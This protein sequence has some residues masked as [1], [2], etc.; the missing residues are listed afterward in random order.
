[1]PSIDNTS[2]GLLPD[3][4]KT[5]AAADP[6]RT[7]ELLLLNRHHMETLGRLSAGI[8]HEINTPL[9]YIKGNLEL[10]RAGMGRTLPPERIAEFERFISPIADGVER[11]A[12]TVNSM[13]GLVGVMRSYREERSV[14]VYSTLV[15]AARL[16]N[17]ELKHASPLYI[18]GRPFSITMDAEAETCKAT[19]NATNI[20]QVWLVILNNAIEAFGQSPLPFEERRIEVSCSAREGGVR[21]L[22]RDNAGPIPDEALGRMFELFESTKQGARASG[23]TWQGQ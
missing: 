9:T 14:N 8:T 17:T 21:V 23:F 12:A 15:Y 18:N 3:E 13:K 20:E 22:I 11:I 7:R 5:A 6:E 10:L 4:E 16:L 19:L 2:K 1:M